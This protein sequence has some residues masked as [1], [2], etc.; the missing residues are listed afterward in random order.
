[1]VYMYSRK[2]HCSFLSLATVLNFQLSMNI[3]HAT[4]LPVQYSSLHLSGYTNIR[5]KN[6]RRF[7]GDVYAGITK[8]G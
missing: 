5:G 6:V 4:W 2:S 8:F 7:M 3:V 1:M